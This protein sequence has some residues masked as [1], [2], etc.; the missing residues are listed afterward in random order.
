M[1]ARLP[2]PK[3]PAFEFA[4]HWEPILQIT[5]WLWALF[6]TDFVC[7]QSDFVITRRVPYGNLFRLRLGRL[8]GDL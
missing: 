2:A 1:L 8:L 6:K 3:H 7:T 5:A 4:F